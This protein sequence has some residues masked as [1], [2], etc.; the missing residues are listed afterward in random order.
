M[1]KN[2]KENG[3][4]IGA[5]L[6]IFAVVMLALII[7][8]LV[9]FR[10]Q[11]KPNKTP[12]DVP[13]TEFDLGS[14]IANLINEAEETAEFTDIAL[15]ELTT[16]EMFSKYDIRETYYQECTVSHGVGENAYK[17]TK[18]ILRDG[19][20]WN[21]R[22]YEGDK[23]TETLI[24]DGT[25]VYVR[26]EIT[27]KSASYAVGG[28]NTPEAFASLPDHSRI[29]A[30]AD[31]YR[32]HSEDKTSELSK[33]TYSLYRTSDLNMLMLILNYRE[34]GLTERYYY[35]LDYG[36]IYHCESSVGGNMTYSMTTTVFSPDITNFVTDSSFTIPK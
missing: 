14:D 9:Y 15:P 27:G 19:K 6:L 5:L 31:D 29:V 22:T 36:M 2:K 35:Y 20:C 24:C 18:H 25:T 10:Q 23:L 32:E 1:G 13:E 17:Q 11:K 33:C 4:A 3:S 30:L 26:N 8:G 16:E 21:V 12:D 7:F 28:T 34:A